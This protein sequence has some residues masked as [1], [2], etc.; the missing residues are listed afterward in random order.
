[1]L[2][3]FVY[4]VFLGGGKNLSFFFF[5][6]YLFVRLTLKCSVFFGTKGMNRDEFRNFL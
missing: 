3:K 1:M 6:A 2:S 5:E 4:V